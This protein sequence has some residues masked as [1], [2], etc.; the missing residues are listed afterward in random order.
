VE[1]TR[2]TEQPAPAEQSGTRWL[3]GEELQTWLGL[4][5][6]IVR[7]PAELDRELQRDSGLTHFEYLVLA[8]LS[9]APD[10]T[11]RMSTLAR[12]AEGQLP[13]LSQVA[14]RLERR[15][16]LTRRPDPA[17]GRSTLATLTD[18]GMAKLAAS[19]PGHVTTVR[20]IVFDS[21]TQAQVRQL[22][23]ISRRIGDAIGPGT[24]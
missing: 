13:R 2:S 18:D 15:G 1:T 11:L 4:V 6:L 14:A 12:F 8:G 23:Q 9:E 17:D 20:R 10:R 21:L 16:W 3:T 22:G 19:A 5:R 7:L 24:Y